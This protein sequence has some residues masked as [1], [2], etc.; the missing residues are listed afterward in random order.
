MHYSKIALFLMLNAVTMES[1]QE[2]LMKYP[3]QD[4]LH[5]SG[6]IC[7]E[8]A[9]FKNTVFVQLSGFLSL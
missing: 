2:T 9:Q 1:S 5:S 6:S 3:L 7:K 8:N 4:G